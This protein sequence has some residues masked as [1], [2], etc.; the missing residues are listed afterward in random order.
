MTRAHKYGVSP[1]D[2]RTYNGDVYDSKAECHRARELDA[3]VQVN[4]LTFWMRQVKFP[5]GLR[6]DWRVDFVCYLQHSVHVSLWSVWVEEVKGYEGHESVPKIRRLWNAHGPFPLSIFYG[7]K[8]GLWSK[9][10][11]IVPAHC[12]TEAAPAEEE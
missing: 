1:K 4:Q 2:A 12:E 9:V 6:D 10:E 5:L 11:R 7:L 8:K 3:L